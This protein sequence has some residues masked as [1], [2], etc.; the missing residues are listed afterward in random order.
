MSYGFVV[1]NSRNIYLYILYFALHS[2][3]LNLDSK[4]T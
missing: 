1:Q 4:Y 2:L 3:H